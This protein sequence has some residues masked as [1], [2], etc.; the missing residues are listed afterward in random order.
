MKP[1]ISVH[2]LD[3]AIPDRKLFSNLSFEIPQGALTCITGEFIF[4]VIQ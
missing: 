3:L 4:G 2:N 1:I